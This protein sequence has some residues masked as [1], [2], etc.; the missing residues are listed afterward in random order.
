MTH[1][2][3]T[4]PSGGI[5]TWRH[6][7]FHHPLQMKLW[8]ETTTLRSPTLGTE[9]RF[10]NEHV[11]TCHFHEGKT[12]LKEG[13][14]MEK[15]EGWNVCLTCF[16]FTVQARNLQICF[17]STVMAIACFV[18]V[19]TGKVLSVL[20]QNIPAY[21]WDGCTQTP[22]GALWFSSRLIFKSSVE[23]RL[24]LEMEYWNQKWWEAHLTWQQLSVATLITLIILRSAALE[25]KKHFKVLS[26]I[27]TYC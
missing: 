6:S 1:S 7:A 21:T 16:A 22:G 27:N 23:V 13:F 14:G 24:H 26:S 12:T 20:C 10:S 4:A 9:L 2:N 3:M 5:P 15:Q 17:A 8:P 18:E 19:A 25:I 11:K